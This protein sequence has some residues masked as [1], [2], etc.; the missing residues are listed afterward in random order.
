MWRSIVSEDY[1]KK[2]LQAIQDGAGELSAEDHRYVSANWAVFTEFVRIATDMGLLGP[3]PPEENIRREATLIELWPEACRRAGV[4]AIPMPDD[5]MR[6]I[7]S[8]VGRAS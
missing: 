4:G 3:R 7:T 2:M 6:A 8:F 5:M 1:K